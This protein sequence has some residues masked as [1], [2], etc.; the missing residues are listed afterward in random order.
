M[1][2]GKRKGAGR[3]PSLNPASKLVTMKV[4]P[5]QHKKFL[6][7]GGSRWVKRLID[8]AVKPPSSA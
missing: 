6:A 7:L 8:E 2:G 1:K 4:T 5:E 3:K